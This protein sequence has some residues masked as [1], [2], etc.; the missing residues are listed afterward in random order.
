MRILIPDLLFNLAEELDDL[1][2]GHANAIVALGEFATV[3]LIIVH[4]AALRFI[5]LK[6]SET[7]LWVVQEHLLS[8][9]VDP[10]F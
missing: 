2:R 8:I 3:R 5:V 4:V 9:V 6:E 7:D 1:I 10:L